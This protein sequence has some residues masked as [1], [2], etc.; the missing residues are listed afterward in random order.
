MYLRIEQIKEEG[1]TLE[2]EEK[3]EVFPELSEMINQGECNFIAPI[4][5]ALRATRIDDMIEVKGE[6]N[7]FVRLPCGRCLKEYDTALK[8]RFDLTYT[9]RIPDAQEDEEQADI[10]IS[11]AEMGLI[12]FAGEEINLQD[13]IQE[14][15]IMAF[16]VKAL[17]RE[18]CQGLCSS[19]G[20]DLNQGDCGCDRLPPDGRFAAL[21]NLKLDT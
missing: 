8:S 10:E 7:T 18:N 12:Y 15:V 19:C 3:P 17:C 6:I 14:Q 11:A 4:K 5:T 1:L 16:P 13:G 20:N 2:F 9:H 21:K